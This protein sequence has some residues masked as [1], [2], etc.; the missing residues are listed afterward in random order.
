MKS[1]KKILENHKV[2]GFCGLPK[3]ILPQLIGKYICWGSQTTI[4]DFEYLIRV[5]TIDELKNQYVIYG[6]W[7]I[8]GKTFFSNH[9]HGKGVPITVWVIENYNEEV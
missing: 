2:T 7:L 4:F 5:D 6:K 8:E 3:D 1:I 9:T